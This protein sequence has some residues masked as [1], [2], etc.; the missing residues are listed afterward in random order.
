MKKIVP[1]YAPQNLEQ[2]FSYYWNARN[3][4]QNGLPLLSGLQADFMKRHGEDFLT[5]LSEQLA[6]GSYKPV[7]QMRYLAPKDGH[8][9][10]TMSILS[11]SDSIVYQAMLNPKFLGSKIDAQLSANVFANRVQKRGRKFF[12]KYQTQ[13]GRFIEAQKLA[14]K[15]GYKYRIELDVKNYY[16]SIDHA[17]L[18]KMMEAMPELRKC[19]KELDILFSQLKVWSESENQTAPHTFRRGLPQGYEASDLLANFYLTPLD[20]MMKQAGMSRKARYL[21]YNDDI[22]VFVKRLEDAHKVIESIYWQLDRLGLST[23]SKGGIQYISDAKQL[24]ALSFIPPYGTIETTEEKLS[25]ADKNID[26]LMQKALQN[27]ASK[28]L[29]ASNDLNKTERSQLR[30]WL[31]CGGGFSGD[32]TEEVLNLLF[33]RPDYAFHAGAYLEKRWHE[34]DFSNLAWKLLQKRKETLTSSQLSTIARVLALRANT[35]LNKR[36]WKSLA[37]SLQNTNDWATALLAIVLKREKLG[38]FELDDIQTLMTEYNH[39]V[40]VEYGFFF[41]VHA[42][43]DRDTI[44]AELAPLVACKSTASLELLGCI[45]NKKQAHKQTLKESFEFSGWFEKVLDR[46]DTSENNLTALIKTDMKRLDD[47]EWEMDD[48]MLRVRIPRTEKWVEFSLQHQY[49]HVFILLL[50]QR[51]QTGR[52]PT[53]LT[54]DVLWSK[55]CVRAASKEGGMMKKVPESNKKPKAIGLSLKRHSKA[56]NKQFVEQAKYEK[57]VTGTKDTVSATLLIFM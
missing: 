40:A 48:T 55:L 52:L 34:T 8:G 3:D 41:T 18:R 28:G 6:S 49:A 57:Q 27:G 12:K 30:Y 50:E 10:R 15:S 22:I 24:D 17:L 2:A 16:P 21:R 36:S 14:V 19:H 29:R 33:A 42:D 38:D 26:E 5:L 39:P 11:L 23:N 13:Y 7:V 47:I 20:K 32:R 9:R 51:Q 25:E 53:G 43:V 1:F 46:I 35:S 4:M 37:R 54:F 56:I 31:R 44:N 45:N